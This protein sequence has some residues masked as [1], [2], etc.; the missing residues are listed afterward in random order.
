MNLPSV[1]TLMRI[2]PLENDKESAKLLRKVLETYKGSQRAMLCAEHPDKFRET[3]GWLLR[4]CRPDPIECKMRMANDLLDGCGIEHC[5][6]VDM[7]RGPPLE[8][9][10]LGDTYD[11]TLCRFRGRFVVSSW[12]DIVEKNERLFREE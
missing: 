1:K 3:A 11:V 8:Y 12:G 5:G 9:V 4:A 7:F 6:E 10:N 2:G